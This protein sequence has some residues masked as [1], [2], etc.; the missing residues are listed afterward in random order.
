MSGVSPCC[1]W[2]PLQHALMS[3]RWEGYGQLY[4][5][6]AEPRI[7]MQEDREKVPTPGDELASWI[8]F[9]FIFFLITQPVDCCDSWDQL[10]AGVL[11]V[12]FKHEAVMQSQRT[13]QHVSWTPLVRLKPLKR[14]WLVEKWGKTRHSGRVL[15]QAG[16][17][18]VQGCGINNC[19]LT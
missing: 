12:E 8:T 13:F 2:H 15:H 6:W 7:T 9:F 5:G 14:L 18:W 3:R 17:W 16:C 1:C 10:L 19:P 4:V 11:P